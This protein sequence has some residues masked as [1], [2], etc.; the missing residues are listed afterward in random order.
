M[1]WLSLAEFPSTSFYAVLEELE[2][3]S[4]RAATIVAASFVEDH[5]ERCIKS[6]LVQDEKL[7]KHVFGSNGALRTF[8]AKINLGYFMGL[9]SRSAWR[10]LDTI[11]D[12]RNDF[13]H[14]LH[15]SFDIDSVKDRCS[16]LLLWEQIKLSVSKADDYSTSKKLIMKIG[17]AVED[18]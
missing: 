9:Y 4:P 5:L 7:A 11:R 18:W 12:I 15:I 17:T 10:E 3:S 14:E 13:A 1:G 16:N 6:R 2:D 8:S